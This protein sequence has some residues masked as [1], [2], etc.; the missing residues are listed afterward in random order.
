MAM[1]D[2]MQERRSRPLGE[3]LLRL[4][5]T[6]FTVTAIVG[7]AAW[8]LWPI[9]DQKTSLWAAEAAFKSGN[10]EKADEILQV[11][12]H[13]HRHDS[14]GHFLYGQVLHRRNHYR[15]AN[16]ELSRALDLGMPREQVRREFGLLWATYDFEKAR[17]ALREEL[18]AHPDDIEVVQAMALG[19]AKAR[20]W[21][22]SEG[23]FNHWVEKRTD[24]IEPLLERATMLMDAG[25]FRKAMADFR[26]IL[27]RKPDNFRAR[28]YLAH[29]LLGDARL[30]EAEDQLLICRQLRSDSPEPLVDL[31]V[32]AMERLDY[33]KAN[34]L[35]TQALQ[36]D[37][38]SHVALTDLGNLQ[39]IQKRYDLA[40]STFRDVVRLYPMDKQAHLKLAQSRRFLGGNAD[41]VRIH[42]EIYRRLDAEE[43]QRSRP[44]RH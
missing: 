38:G 12:T 43:E 17:G 33:T 4:I 1:I 26:E 16:D 44:R 7:V 9:Y 18:E 2:A 40:V 28:L 22:E 3:R 11:Y 34:T 14:Y 41:E 19:S 20:L 23:Y 36:L 32:C 39:L 42:E 29:C 8:Y 24:D 25:D 13:V 30:R 35:L 31:A 10:L 27:K 5:V 6:S 21:E 15:E 37:P